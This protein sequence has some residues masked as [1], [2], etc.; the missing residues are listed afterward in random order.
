MFEPGRTLIWKGAH[1]P[2]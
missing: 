2:L 1:L